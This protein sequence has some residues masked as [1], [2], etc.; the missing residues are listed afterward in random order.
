MSGNSVVTRFAPS[1][2]GE[3]H[4]GNARTALFNYLYAHKNGGRFL[5]RIEDTD[6]ERSQERFVDSL[7]ADLAWLGLGHDD[8][9]LRQS[10]RSEFYAEQFARLEQ[11]AL[12]YPC[13]CTPRELKLARDAQMTAGR[14]PRYAGTC[15]HLS[16]AQRAERRAAGIQSTLRFEVPQGTRIEF[17]DLVH[18]PQSF[19]SDDIGDFIVRRADGTPAFFFCNACD[20]SASGVT[21]V[22]RGDDHLTNTPRQLMLLA[23]LNERAPG[24][25]HVSL[26]T[27][28]DGSPLSKRHG[29]TSVHELRDQGYLPHALR[30]HLFR[31]G[32]STPV[33]G[34]LSLEQMCAAFDPTHLQRAPAYFDTQ[35][36]HVWQK[37]AVHAQS[38]DQARVWL[39]GVLPA[40]DSQIEAAFVRAVLPNLVLPADARHWIEV[41]FGAPPEPEANA[42]AVIAT[43]GTAFFAAA[44]GAAATYG[45]DFV[46]IAEATRLATGVKGAALF[47]P[48][49]VALTGQL[50]GPEL[51]ALLLAMA[52]DAARQ[53]LQRFA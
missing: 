12:V 51:K 44:S 17:D 42:R 49:R 39:Q 31:L 16:E 37:D 26:L 40:L 23:A 34:L 24:Y 38:V 18:G 30:N 36:L 7:L 5:L 33:N 19:A 2:S 48:L 3:L 14:P 41:T 28:A 47:Q 8:L 35:Q 10:R 45:N 13:F 27:G 1:P 43:A 20:D 6:R 22:L 46:R 32:H 4:L 52:P 9:P 11:L 50:H 53:R 21:L 25:G 15:R 29:A